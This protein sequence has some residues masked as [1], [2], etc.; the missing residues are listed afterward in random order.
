[1]IKKINKIFPIAIV[2]FVV[3]ELFL[4]KN[5]QFQ[6]GIL[7]YLIFIVTLYIIDKKLVVSFFVFNLPL[8]PIIST[9]YKIMS[10]I[11][12]HEIIYG[13]AFIVLLELGAKLKITLNKYQKLSIGFIYLLF[14]INYFII[15]KDS[16]LGLQKNSDSLYL[17]KNFIRMFLY[18]QSLAILVKIIYNKNLY[19]YILIGMKMSLIVM[20]LSMLFSKYL[21]LMGANMSKPETAIIKGTATRFLGFY[22]AGGDE[23]SAP[24]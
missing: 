3:I 17:M 18:Y 1:M 22:G 9:E 15:F 7:L 6:A 16:L 14:F 8:V 23:N 12:P 24:A 21:L 20:V 11:G 19:E 13:F 4:T 5:G 10:F 2:I